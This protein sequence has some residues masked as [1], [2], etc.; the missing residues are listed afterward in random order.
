VLKD[1]IVMNMKRGNMMEIKENQTLEIENLLSYRGK[2]KQT[3]IENI[4]KDMDK[5]ISEN[6]RNRIGNPITATFGV[7]GDDMDLEI[8]LPIDKEIS[9][10]GEYR[11]KKKIRIENAVLISHKGNPALIQNT[12]NILNKYIMENKMQPITVGYNVTR[13][14]DPLDVENTIIDVFVGINPNIL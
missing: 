7:E 12:F 10:I 8:L 3:D 11:F 14:A 6:G 4:G 13:K 9:D 1:I 2:V 5:I